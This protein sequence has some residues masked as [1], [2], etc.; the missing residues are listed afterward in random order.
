MPPLRTIA[1]FSAQAV[2]EGQDSWAA[3]MEII[4]AMRRAEW[5]VELYKPEY[6]QGS[7]PGIF[8]RLRKIAGTQRDLA[9]RIREY[10]AL[11]VRAHP[12][13]W[14]LAAYAH[15]V[16]IP[17]IQESNGSWEDAFIAWPSMRR[18]AP[19][20]VAMQRSQYRIAD[21]IV[22]VSVTL[23]DWLCREAG[24]DDAIVS[25]NGANDELFCPGGPRPMELPDR[26]VVF[27]GQ[28]APWQR[29]D[30][31]IAAAEHPEWPKDVD[32][33][34]VGDGMLRPEVEAAAGRN[35][36][37]HY[38]GMLAYECVPSVVSG[39]LAAA[40]LTYAP[41]RAGYSPLKLYEAMACGVPI[42]CSDTPGQA[43]YVR[44]EDAGIVVPP[45]DPVA[46]ARAAATLAER[47]EEARAMGNRG[48]TAVEE[49]YSWNARA[50]QRMETIEAAI[51]HPRD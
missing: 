17:V 33:V 24:R 12:L 34:I 6:G 10:D 3:V 27:F 9:R 23:A 49:R 22:A 48:M 16:G 5:T 38:F 41:D 21:A 39:A 28:F 29:L 8:E 15:R 46:V 32:L 26:Y 31:L 44:E 40:V 37:V 18:I 50:R 43:E 30:V 47:P 19:L 13:A 35:P 14:P 36:H 42:I 51:E 45:N 2:A 11:Y 7:V 4:W 20:V 1:Y 25:P